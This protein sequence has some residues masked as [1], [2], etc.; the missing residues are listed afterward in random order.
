MTE[1]YLCLITEILFLAMKIKF[2]ERGIWNEE[3][4]EL[5]FVNK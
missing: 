5:L 2:V 3:G 4:F 1:D